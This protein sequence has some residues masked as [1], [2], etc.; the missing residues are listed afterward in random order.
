MASIGN[1]FIAGREQHGG[2]YKC[3]IMFS[4]KAISPD[5][6]ILDLQNNS[7]QVEFFKNT[8]QIVARTLNELSKEDLLSQGFQ[9]VQQTL[10]LLSIKGILSTT[11]E[12]P[13]KSHR[14]IYHSSGRLIFYCYALAELPIS[15]DF[16]IKRIDLNG[17]EIKEESTPS[18]QINWHESFRYYRLSQ[19]TSDLFE[20]YR[21]LFLA[22]EALLNKI[23]PKKK[24]E[25]EGIWLRRSLN[26]VNK[27]AKLSQFAPST[28]KDAIEFII[29]SQYKDIRCKLQHAKMPQAKL[30][31]SQLDPADVQYAYSE[32]VRIWR[33]IASTHLYISEGGGVVTYEGFS[34]MMLNTFSSSP[35]IFYTTDTSPPTH[36]DTKISPQGLPTYKIESA[37]FFEKYK[38]GVVRIIGMEDIHIQDPR[39]LMPISRIAFMTN[40]VVFSILYIKDGLQLIG[41]DAWECIQDL[42][43]VNA[44]QPKT[45]FQ[46]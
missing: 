12:S 4:M 29:K 40:D 10:D 21:N 36:Q 6:I 27:K 19:S 24:A 18:P 3:G 1:I 44:S 28:V 34:Y 13:A 45:E 22:L 16:S 25:Q 26:E 17:N 30:P 5:N 23:C 11:L 2:I 39:F 37:N 14:G 35:N 43:L 31:H 8:N 7:W 41:I 9:I 33:H 15:I 42:Q 38:P 20:A 46:N 32:L